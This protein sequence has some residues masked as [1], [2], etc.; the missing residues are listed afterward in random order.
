M[1]VEEFATGQGTV[2]QTPQPLGHS[3]RALKYIR[4]RAASGNSGLLYVGPSTVGAASG[5]ALIASDAAAESVT[6]EVDDVAKVWI[7][8]SQADQEYSYLVV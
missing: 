6:V 7:V 3:R 5:Y 8:A 4:I 1:T 2:G